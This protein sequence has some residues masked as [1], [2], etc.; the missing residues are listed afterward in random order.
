MALKERGKCMKKCE[1]KILD[2]DSNLA[3]INKLYSIAYCDCKY[4]WDDFF[5]RTNKFYDR[6]LKN[7]KEKK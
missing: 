6:I 1:Q 2:T 7:K 3:K 4:D 5:N